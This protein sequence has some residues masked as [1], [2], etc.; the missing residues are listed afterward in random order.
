MSALAVYVCW[1]AK[2]RF[3]SRSSRHGREVS[4][5]KVQDTGEAVCRGREEILMPSRS[6][7]QGKCVVADCLIQKTPNVVYVRPEVRMLAAL[8]DDR[9]TARCLVPL[10]PLPDPHETEPSHFSPR[11]TLRRFRSSAMEVNRMDENISKQHY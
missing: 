6:F 2:V 1:T 4:R 8:H 3:E 10:A 5:V 11:F 7:R 9:N